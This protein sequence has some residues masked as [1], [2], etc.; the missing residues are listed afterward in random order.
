MPCE[1]GLESGP[2]TTN[3]PDDF[4]MPGSDIKWPKKKKKKVINWATV[5]CCTMDQAVPSSL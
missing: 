5:E 4:Q 1:K 2:G 3:A